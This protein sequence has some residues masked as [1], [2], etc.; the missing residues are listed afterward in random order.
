MSTAQALNG[1]KSSSLAPVRSMIIITKFKM[2]EAMSTIFQKDM[3]Y[4]NLWNQICFA[5]KNAKYNI[6]SSNIITEILFAN[7]KC[8][9]LPLLSSIIFLWK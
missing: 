7:P 2:S 9:Q 5:S 8:S 3:K 6:N 4:P 1:I